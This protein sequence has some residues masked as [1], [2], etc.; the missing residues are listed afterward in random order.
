M[1]ESAAAAH[2][3]G[4]FFCLG[5]ER[6]EIQASNEEECFCC[7]RRRREGTYLRLGLREGEDEGDKPKV[8]RE[9]GFL[10]SCLEFQ[11]P[12]NDES[13]KLG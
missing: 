1:D 4:N 10:L 8:K 6:D 5:N 12:L 9:I 11:W 2:L 7:Y 13:I 3:A